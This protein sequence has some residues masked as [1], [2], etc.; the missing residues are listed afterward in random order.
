MMHLQQ[1]CLNF[2]VF[3]DSSIHERIAYKCTVYM[4]VQELITVELTI[5]LSC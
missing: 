3:V 5:G 2:T 1:V 4:Y